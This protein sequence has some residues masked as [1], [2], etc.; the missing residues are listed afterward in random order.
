SLIACRTQNDAGQFVHALSQVPHLAESKLV[1]AIERALQLEIYEA[2]DLLFSWTQEQA[3]RMTE[4]AFVG[5]PDGAELNL[6][7]GYPAF[8][9]TDAP[10]VGNTEQR[11]HLLGEIL[12]AY[13]NADGNDALRCAIVEALAFGL[14]RA[15]GHAGRYAEALGIVE[16]ALSVRPY[17][18]HL[19]AAKHALGLKLEGTPVPP[20]LEKFIGVDNGHMK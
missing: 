18:I 13:A 3:G 5:M 20:R 19:K 8:E 12:D 16:Q 10:S 1:R 14:S 7:Y 15:L 4:T 2:A 11:T 17:S 6:F 9:L